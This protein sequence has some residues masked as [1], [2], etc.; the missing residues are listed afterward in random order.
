MRSE[1]GIPPWTIRELLRVFQISQGERGF[2]A[3]FRA[4][5]NTQQINR[6]LAA[7]LDGVHGAQL[8]DGEAQRPQTVRSVKSI[9]QS[10]YVRTLSG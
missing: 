4:A 9:D 2:E 5:A 7:L 10:F 6:C 1:R 8:C 3:S